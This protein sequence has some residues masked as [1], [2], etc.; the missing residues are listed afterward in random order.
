MSPTSY[1]TAPPREVMITMASA[2]GQFG[3]ERAAYDISA[4]CCSALHFRP[5]TG[6]HSLGR[7][8]GFV[9][10]LLVRNL[11][12]LINQ[13]GSAPRRLQRHALDVI[14]LR[15]TVFPGYLAAKV[16][17]QGKGDAILL[18][19]SEVG[20]G[21]IHAHTQNLGVGAFQ[22]AQV[23]LEGFHLLGSTP[24]KGENI[25][26]QHHVFFAAKIAQRDL[27]QVVPVKG[28][29]GEIGRHVAH[30]ELHWRLGF[31]RALLARR[32][33]ALRKQRRQQAAGQ[34]KHHHP[35]QPLVAHHVSP[36][37]RALSLFPKRDAVNRPLLTC[38]PPELPVESRQATIRREYAGGGYV[39]FS[40]STPGNRQ[41]RHVAE[42]GP[43]F[44][45]SL[46]TINEIFFTVIERNSDQVMMYKQTDKWSS[47]SSRELYREVLG[48]ARSLEKW[49]IRQGDR[50][51]IL[52]E[53]RPEW[54]VADFA[55]QLLGAITV[56]IY[57]TLTPEQTAFILQDSGARVIFLSTAA[58][59]QKFLAAR[60][61]TRVENAVIMD[62]VETPDAVPMHRL[63]H[64]GPAGRD[65]ELD[66]RARGI[67]PADLA[68]IIYTS[69]TTGV[70]KGAMLTHGNLACNVE[71]SLH[72][73][74][75]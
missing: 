22:L 12:R 20:E 58:Q 3:Q 56:P 37:M 10:H 32:P 35:L 43:F 51:A 30:L 11:A 39:F 63:M 24:G 5:H 9:V 64:G 61:Q 66:A 73:E 74:I 53:N 57:G 28:Q 41:C 25:K 13:E 71:Y 40:P 45:M 34:Q 67:G 8:H 48:V 17:Q 72:E 23:A 2:S 7:V 27:F 42:S 50:V 15:Q 19:E 55:T 75:G 38:L 4:A 65:A 44:A 36:H 18:R 14:V 70:P 60:A 6:V 21:A 49:G 59:L 69:G 46:N 29:Q 68:T 47:I 54:A 62:Q 26:R 52:S 33:C 31:G 16:A 1:Q